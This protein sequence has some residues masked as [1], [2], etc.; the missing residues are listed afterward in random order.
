MLVTGIFPDDLKQSRV[1]PIFKDGD[2]SECENYKP[3]SVISA[4]SK[5]L[6]TLISDQLALHLNDNN[7]IVKQQSG[8]RKCHSTETALL[9][10]TDQYLLNMD[11]SILNGVLFLDLKKAFDTFHINDLPNCL[12]ETQASMF[13]DDTSISSS[14]TS[15]LE[16]EN[17]I[18]ND[19]HNVNIWLETNKLTLNT[20]KTEFMLIASKRKLKQYSG[21]P[22][23][24]IGSHD[25]KQVI[26]KKVLGIILDEELK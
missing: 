1:T 5:V 12:E 11:K 13:A 25:I 7:I 14:G 17:K 6:E 24:T 18:N 3:I 4:I 15:L 23:I 9:H 26:N 2:K 22:N 10:K 19:L 20:E 21:N 8:F 16:I